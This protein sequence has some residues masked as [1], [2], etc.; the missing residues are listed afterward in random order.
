[1]NVDVEL[2]GL[3]SHSVQSRVVPAAEN[4]DMDATGVSD[5][6]TQLLF[7]EWDPDADQDHKAKLVKYG[8]SLFC[9]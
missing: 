2:S 3:N 8:I 9:E 7:A 1:M 4:K 6:T 5:G